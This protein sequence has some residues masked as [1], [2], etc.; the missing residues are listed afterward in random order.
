MNTAFFLL[1]S[2]L[3]IIDI[4]YT[5]RLIIGI[6]GYMPTAQPAICPF[7]AQFPV[8]QKELRLIAYHCYV[9]RQNA[10]AVR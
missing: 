9:A 6:I 8:N 3:L 2:Q 5:D 7:V 4:G 10:N 1:K